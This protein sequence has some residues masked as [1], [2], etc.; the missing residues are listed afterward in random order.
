M[1]AFLAGRRV[2]T[3]ARKV[4][5]YVILQE[6]KSD[7]FSYFSTLLYVHFRNSREGK[8]TSRVGNPCAPHPLNKSELYYE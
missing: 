8:S 6:G 3:I 1:W 7:M 5:L 2:S 4:P